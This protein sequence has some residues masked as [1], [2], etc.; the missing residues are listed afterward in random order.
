MG[1]CKAAQD[2]RSTIHV[3]CASYSSTA[4]AE[5]GIA[6]N[7]GNCAASLIDGAGAARANVQ[8]V[9]TRPGFG[10]RS[11]GHVQDTDAT[12]TANRH[13]TVD[14]HHSGAADVIGSKR[15]GI[16]AFWNEILTGGHVDRAGAVVE[17]AAA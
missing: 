13:P 12:A 15:S 16:A 14:S 17:R 3:P 7:A 1:D 6:K 9:T 8:V 2:C 11:A 10:E 4:L 5:P